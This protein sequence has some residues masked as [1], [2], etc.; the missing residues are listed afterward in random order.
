MNKKKISGILYIIGTLLLAAAAYFA[1]AGFDLSKVFGDVKQ[2]V[3]T[4][5]DADKE[6]KPAEE[7]PAPMTPAPETKPVA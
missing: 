3:E 1:G 7:T 2:G 5:K 4:I 6:Q